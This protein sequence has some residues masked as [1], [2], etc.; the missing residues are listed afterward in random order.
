MAWVYSNVINDSCYNKDTIANVFCVFNLAFLFLLVQNAMCRCPINSKKNKNKNK[1]TSSFATCPIMLGAIYLTFS[2]L[3]FQW[4]HFSTAIII[5]VFFCLSFISTHP[6]V[7]P[8]S[9][10]SVTNI[11]YHL[12]LVLGPFIVI[13][14]EHNSWQS[15]WM[16]WHWLL[17]WPRPSDYRFNEWGLVPHQYQTL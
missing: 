2:A 3:F 4:K 15:K 14:G 12:V 11:S 7:P 10:I 13:N 17:I 8:P 6:Q 1:K 16:Q 9:P 5:M